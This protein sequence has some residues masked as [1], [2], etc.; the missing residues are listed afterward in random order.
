[1]W[2]TLTSLSLWVPRTWSTVFVSLPLS[3]CLSSFLLL[4]CR[5][6]SLRPFVS[7]PESLSF[8]VSLSLPRTYARL[9]YSHV[10]SFYFRRPDFRPL[11]LFLFCHAP[12]TSTPSTRPDTPSFLPGVWTGGWGVRPVRTVSCS[13]NRFRDH[14]HL[15]H[16]SHSTAT[17]HSSLHDERDGYTSPGSAETDQGLRWTLVGT[18]KWDRGGVAPSVPGSPCTFFRTRRD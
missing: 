13:F 7:L 8:L 5:L 15:T 1:M 3:R 6:F 10:V 12:S 11:L 4:L 9:A 2:S 16:T 18:G 14:T 17:H